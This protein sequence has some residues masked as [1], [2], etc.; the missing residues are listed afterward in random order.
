VVSILELKQ[1]LAGGGDW[2]V[3]DSRG[4][5]L[6]VAV[7][8]DIGL[9]TLLVVPVTDALKTITTD[10]LVDQSLDRDKFW[11]V[12]GYALNRV[13]VGRLGSSDLTPRELYDAVSELRLGWQVKALAEI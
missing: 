4:D 13:V 10:R 11:A 1:R 3:F 7:P 2:V 5:A 12:E 8:P 9:A 6:D